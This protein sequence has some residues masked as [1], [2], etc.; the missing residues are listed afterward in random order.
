MIFTLASHCPD[1]SRGSCSLLF[2]PPRPPLCPPPPLPVPSL[3]PFAC[4]IPSP[5]FPNVSAAV[6]NLFERS[7]CVRIEFARYDTT[8]TS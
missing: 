2:L 6:A 5:E 4:S 1:G 8:R 7:I 3:V